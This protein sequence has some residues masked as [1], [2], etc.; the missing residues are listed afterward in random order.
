MY[1]DGSLEVKKY[2][3]QDDLKAGLEALDADDSVDT[4]QPNFSYENE[5]VTRT[6]T[7]DSYSKAQWALSNNGTFKGYR[8]SLKSKSGVDVSAEKAWRYYTPARRAVIALIDTGVQYRHSELTGS[9]WTNTDEIAG[10]GVDDDGN[11]IC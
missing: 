7:N 8:T 11:G 6:V 4:Y 9:F 1:N 2:D 3:S 5:A 10:N